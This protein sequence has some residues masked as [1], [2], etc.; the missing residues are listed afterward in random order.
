VKLTCASKVLGKVKGDNL[1][2]DDV[3]AR[4]DVGG[5]R[6]ISWGSVHYEMRNMQSVTRAE[7]AKRWTVRTNELL[8]PIS[9]R[10][11]ASLLVNFEPSRVG[12]IELVT[13]NRSTIR[14]VEEQWTRIMWPLCQTQR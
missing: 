13:S 8:Y 12:R 3:V 11:L 9:S 1:V 5:D 2:P 4:S 7:G 10:L 14:H 6:D